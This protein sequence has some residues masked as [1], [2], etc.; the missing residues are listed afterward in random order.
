MSMN[1]KMNVNKKAFVMLL[2][3][4]KKKCGKM[5]L[6]LTLYIII[7]NQTIVEGN[8]KLVFKNMIL[9]TNLTM[10]ASYLISIDVH[11]N[12]LNAKVFAR[13]IMIMTVFTKQPH[14]EIRK[15]VF[16]FHKKAMI[17]SH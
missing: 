4:Y 8:A 17:K 10:I 7:I 14:T 11:H 15:I 6:V 3:K 2:S 16:L 12:V 1:V 9:A 5:I 13:K